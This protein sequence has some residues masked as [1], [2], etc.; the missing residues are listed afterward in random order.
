MKYNCDF[1]N[2]VVSH[3]K[4]LHVKTLKLL[5]ASLVVLCCS[6]DEP[7]ELNSIDLHEDLINSQE[8]FNKKLQGTWEDHYT[9]P[10]N[11]VGHVP[12]TRTVTF[13]GDSIFSRSSFEGH[14]WYLKGTYDL[15]VSNDSLFIK[16]QY[17][18]YDKE[19]SLAVA[20]GGGKNFF[21]IKFINDEEIIYESMFSNYETIF[22]KQNN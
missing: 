16:K 19:T 22:K 6:K 3:R 10:I 18:F 12:H 13:I 17:L 1:L 11:G 4:T 2:V 8:S 20:S 14:K 21:Y 15:K 9:E 5:L 7:N